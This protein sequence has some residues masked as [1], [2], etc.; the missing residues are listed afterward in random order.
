MPS[1]AL[2]T[3]V[4]RQPSAR[5]RLSP[6]AEADLAGILQQSGERFGEDASMRYAALV[7]QALDDLEADPRRL[8]VREV[9]A[10][11]PLLFTYY[12]SSSRDGV[13]GARVRSPRHLLLFRLREGILQILRIL[14]DRQDVSDYLPEDR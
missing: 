2:E 11:H 12:L 5:A 4:P 9:S 14:H 13:S 6:Q 3:D 7:V 10:S 8:G 1:L